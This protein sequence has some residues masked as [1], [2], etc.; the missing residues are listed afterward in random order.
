MGHNKKEILGETPLNMIRM[1][2]F[3][4]L[5]RKFSILD[6]LI[7]VV[8]LDDSNSS[9]ENC[10]VVQEHHGIDEYCSNACFPFWVRVDVEFQWEK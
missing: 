8:S 4:C 10:Y 5:I 9:L 7:S 6:N 3:P 1:K 2:D